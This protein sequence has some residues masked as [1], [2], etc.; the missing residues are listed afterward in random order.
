MDIS[1]PLSRPSILV[2]V[3]SPQERSTLSGILSPVYAVALVS[4]PQ[5]ART[6]LDGDVLPDLILL[7]GEFP[8]DAAINLCKQLKAQSE[9]RNVPII[10]LHDQTHVPAEFL[11]LEL[12]IDEYISKPI[13]ATILLIRVAHHLRINSAAAF[14]KSMKSL[15]EQEVSHRSRE[16]GI[17]KEITVLI[18][19]SL[20]EIRDIDTENHARRTQR[21][22]MALANYLAE[23]SRFSDQLDAKARELL[24][25]SV[26]LHDIGKVGIPDAILLKACPLDSGEREIMKT[27]TTM[28]RDAIQRA[29]NQLGITVPFLGVVKELTYSHHERWDGHGYPEGMVGTNIP[30]SARI[31]AVADVYDALVTR[32]AYKVPLPHAQAVA[33]IASKRSTDFDPYITDAFIRIQDQFLAIS[34]LFSEAN[35]AAT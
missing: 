34:N 19:A 32:R 26:P 17:L 35:P 10:I 30:L 21:Y 14:I 24:F 28:G 15:L 27:H 5:E 11:A 7:D 12:G 8:E 1:V 16:V 2:V 23:D 33:Y 4:T 20:A 3:E 29:E 31:M 18:L 25:S 22:V 13:E 6:R 9:T